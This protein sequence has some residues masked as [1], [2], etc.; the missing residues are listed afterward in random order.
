MS[1]AFWG[2]FRLLGNE[3]GPTASK[4][5]VSMYTNG[6]DSAW[7]EAPFYRHSVVSGNVLACGAC[8]C[9]AREHGLSLVSRMR[10]SLKSLG[11]KCDRR[12]IS[13]FLW[14]VLE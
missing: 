5:Q 7:N 12:A 3:L 9:D 8:N 11:L 1:N 4:Y 14:S 10:P 2:K 6:I 13:H